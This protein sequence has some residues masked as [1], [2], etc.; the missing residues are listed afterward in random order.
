MQVSGQSPPTAYRFSSCVDSNY[1]N[2]L[3]GVFLPAISLERAT[4]LPLYKQLYQSI[5]QSIL[6]GT[7]RK[8]LHLP[9]TRTL[10]HELRTSSSLH[11]SSY[12][13]K[14]T[15]NRERVRERL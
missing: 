9:S 11:L 6:R 5:R 10:A 2:A 14:A 3:S 12:L 8:G 4:S 13:P 7:L 15:S 1:E